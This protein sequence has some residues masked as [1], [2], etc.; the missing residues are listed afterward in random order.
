MSRGLMTGKR[1]VLVSVSRS[2][3]R[4][5][6][7]LLT[8]PDF[9]K[10]EHWACR[11]GSRR[12]GGPTGGRTTGDAGDADCGRERG[13]L[14][15]GWLG[16]GPPRHEQGSLGGATPRA[17]PLRLSHLQIGCASRS[18]RQREQRVNRLEQDRRRRASYK[19]HGSGRYRRRSARVL[20]LAKRT[21]A[22]ANVDGTMLAARAT[23]A[24]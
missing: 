7:R 18:R 14:W 11:T 3:V 15:G 13:D 10:A 9:C 24:T 17:E 20:R 4:V 1:S 19:S 16:P 8:T 6:I 12:A 22:G 2:R 5:C 23:K 21:S